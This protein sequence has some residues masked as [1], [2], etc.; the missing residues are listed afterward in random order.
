MIS[1]DCSSDK[2]LPMKRIILLIMLL[3]R[4]GAF[5]ISRRA[6][7]HPSRSSIVQQCRR[8]LQATSSLSPEDEEYLLQ[9]VACAKHGLGHTFP[10]PAV[11]CVLVQKDK[12]VIGQGFHPQ[13]GFPHAEVFALLEAAGHVP[14]GIAAASSVVNNSKDIDLVRDLTAQYAT[15]DG[16]NALFGQLSVDRPGVTAYVT[17]EPCCHTGK[18]P[19]CAVSLALAQVD[20]VVVG[21]RDPNPRVDGGGVQLLRDAGITVDLA[22]T[23]DLVV[24]AACHGLVANFCKRIT[25]QEDYDDYM[26][27]GVRR[28]LR[29]LAGRLKREGTLAQIAFGGSRSEGDEEVPLKPEWMEHLDDVLWDKELVVVKLNTAVSKKKDAKVLGERIAEQLQAHV[30]QTLGHTCLLYRP[31]IPPVLD[32]E[33]LMLEKKEEKQEE[34]E[35]ISS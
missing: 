4:T 11:G 28:A 1:L 20:R 30:A 34:K 16:P 10:N 25:P 33:A 8:G 22:D 18:T 26:T 9:A 3:A 12:G 23:T 17:L 7:V 5:Q 15:P 6:L 29:S 21:F 13:A 19:P 24:Q 35:E 32:L 27:G 14:D 31:A 2:Y